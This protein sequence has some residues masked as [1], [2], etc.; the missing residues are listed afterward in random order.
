MSS[1]RFATKR[2]LIAGVAAIAIAAGAGAA[3]ATT[4]GAFDPKEEAEA[5]QASVA[6]K[7][8]V[9]TKQ[10]QDAYKAAALERV[11]A[12]LAA[13]RIT[14]E[15]AEALKERIE[16]GDFLGPM[17]WFGG[18]HMHGPGFFGAFD[19]AAEYLG[20][21]P[22]ELREQLAS[23]KSLADVA[24]AEGKSVEG[25]KNAILDD[26]KERL[27]QA[28]EDGRLTQAQADEIL[29][30]LESKIDDLV[31]DELPEGPGFRGRHFGMHGFWG[32]PGTRS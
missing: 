22:A 27:D 12:A 14:E 3:L 11:D 30:R 26:A 6:E 7:L 2:T 17:G 15:Q 8:G 1:R 4:T 24:K 20:L 29:D 9:T 10:L 32:P 31:N 28:V 23:G 5:F 19:A 18:P 13:G 16:S 21:T 25:L